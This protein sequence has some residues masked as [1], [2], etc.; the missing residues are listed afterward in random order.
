MYREVVKA[1]EVPQPTG[2]PK[3]RCCKCSKLVERL[4]KQVDHIDPVIPPGQKFD[5][6]WNWY[7]DRMF[8][9]KSNLQVMCKTCHNEKSVGENRRRRECKKKSKKKRSV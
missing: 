9:E 5:G 1:S 6:D 4:Q 2:K 3:Y 7:R 8:V